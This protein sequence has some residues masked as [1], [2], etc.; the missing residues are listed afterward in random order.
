MRAT[1]LALA[2]WTLPALAVD[3]SGTLILAPEADTVR[4]GS[5]YLVSP[6]PEHSHFGELELWLREG[7]VNAQGSLRWQAA[8]GAVPRQRGVLKQIYYDG[9]V[10]AD[11]LGWTVGKKV[12]SW[13]VGFGFRPL[14]VIQRED[15][16]GVNLPAPEGVPLLALD[17]FSGN[18]AG[19]FVFTPAWTLPEAIPGRTDDGQGK[20]PPA[21]AWHGFRLTA[22]GDDLH[23][24]ARLSRDRHL[25]VGV[26]FVHVLGEESS[27]YGAA[28]WERRYLKR[29]NSLAEY[30]GL[31]AAADPTRDF[32]R[33]DGIRAVLGAQWTGVSGWSLLA[34]GWLDD[35]AYRIEEWRRL[36]AL[37][38]RQLAATG[39]APAAAI[40]ANVAASGRAYLATNLLRENLLLRLSYDNSD[41]FR[42]Y[43]EVL[44]TPADGGKLYTLGLVDET[45]RLRFTFGLRQTGGAVRSV[46]ANVPVGRQVWAQWRWALF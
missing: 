36:D 34:E 24:L 11:G 28:L 43:A 15:R 32:L 44:A 25:E 1:A 37:T 26:G 19:T 31:L 45:D 41:G 27:V 4:T 13:G 18:D 42:P 2:A 7:G 30:G 3:I 39:V 14:D 35:E 33:H 8:E 17:R 46:L 5:P 22:E 21:L 10:S 29:L 12:L 38:A 40:A 20:R 16:R 23:A 6:I 9:E